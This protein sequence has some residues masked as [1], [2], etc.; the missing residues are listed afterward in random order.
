MTERITKQK[1]APTKRLLA[2][3]LTVT[4]SFSAIC[5]WVLWHAGD[6]DYLHSRAAANFV[7]EMLSTTTLT[8]MAVHHGQLHFA[9][10]IASQAIERIEAS[11]AVPPAARNAA[12]SA[13]T[14]AMCVT[15]S[16][17]GPPG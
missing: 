15:N 7:S 13:F 1:T 5:G 10:E 3:G 12:R 9:Y 11:E 17:C 6:R 14:R 16:P 4:L 2:L 8:Q